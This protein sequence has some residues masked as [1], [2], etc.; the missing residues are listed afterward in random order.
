MAILFIAQV[1]GSTGHSMSLAVGGIMAAEISGSNLWSGL[2]VAVG[3]LGAAAASWPLARLMA[4]LGRR[5]GLAL[6]YGIA[7]IGAVLSI[8]GVVVRDFTIFLVGMTLFGAS[9]ASNLLARYAAADMSPASE[10]GRAMGLIVWGS[11]VGSVLGPNLMGL[12]VH[13]GAWLGLSAAASA[14][15]ISVASYAFAAL[16]VQ[17]VLRPDPMQIARRDHEATADGRRP[18]VPRTPGAIFSD[19]RVRIAYVTLVLGQLVMIGTTSTSPVYLHDQG[20]SVG[21]IGF[22][23]SMHLGGMYIASPLSGWVCD[24]IGRIPSIVAG[25]AGLV[26]AVA[27]AGLVPGQQSGI[28]AF[29][30][31]LNGIGWNLAFVAGSALL[32]DALAPSERA[33]IQGFADLALGLAGALGSTLGGMILGA[34]GF[35]ILNA[36]GALC[37]LGPLVAA[38]LV[39]PRAFRPEHSAS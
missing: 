23:V 4:R 18:A 37:V 19:I 26:A 9:Q 31:F 34:W 16:L 30:L 21:T 2:P 33:S 29:G 6:G 27:M 10:R 20:H 35:A 22:A 38:W 32:T 5:P 7:V 15:L 36:A 11:T 14:F 13:V 1:A 28:V 8:V 25:A 3:A 24:R 39:A 12:A 17:A